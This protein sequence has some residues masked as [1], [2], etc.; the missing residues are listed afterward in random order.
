MRGFRIELGEVEDSLIR[1]P[2]VTT[3]AVLVK[4]KP[5]ML[6]AFVQLE[7]NAS[8][9][10]LELKMFAG[11]TLAKYMQPDRVIFLDALPM[12]TSG[13]TDRKAL[14]KLPTLPP[15]KKRPDP[16]PLSRRSARQSRFSMRPRVNPAL[17]LIQEIWE[18]LL[19]ASDVDE[20][21]NFFEV[22][23]NSVLAVEFLAKLKA[24]GITSITMRHFFMNPVASDLA[25]LIA[26]DRHFQSV[27][28]A[29]K[30]STLHR[31]RTT[32][33]DVYQATHENPALALVKQIW[34]IVLSTS[35]IDDDANFFEI[36]G[37]SIMAVDVITRF[38]SQNITTVSMR[39]FFQNPVASSLAL[40]IDDEAD[41][42][43]A[44]PSPSA[45][46]ARKS[47][48]S[49]RASGRVFSEL[50][51]TAEYEDDAEAGTL[52]TVTPFSR[53]LPMTVA[54]IVCSLC[55]VYAYFAPAAVVY[56]VMLYATEGL[57]LYAAMAMTPVACFLFFPM[58]LAF[59]A[60]LQLLILGRSVQPGVHSVNS[61]F[62]LRWWLAQRLQYVAEEFVLSG[63]LLETPM[64]FIYYRILG[65]KIGESVVLKSNALCDPSLIEIGDGAVL[66]HRSMLACST[67]VG[68]QL[69]LSR[70]VIGAQ[71]E[72][73]YNATVSL[74]TT[75]GTGAKLADY[76]VTLPNA[77]LEPHTEYV[78][79]PAEPVDCGKTM[80]REPQAYPLG[81]PEPMSMTFLTGVIKMI[82]FYATNL[83]LAAAS[84]FAYWV[85]VKCDYAPDL[86]LSY[87]AFAI[88]LMFPFQISPFLFF[89]TP[90][91]LDATYD[92]YVAH[93]DLGLAEVMCAWLLLFGTVFLAVFCAAIV[94]W[95]SVLRVVYDRPSCLEMK[96]VSISES[97][98]W[99]SRYAM[100]AAAPFLSG[101][102]YIPQFLNSWY[103][104]NGA[105]VG[106]GTW[107]GGEVITEPEQFKCG[108]GVMTGDRSF[109]AGQHDFL[110]SDGTRMLRRHMVE[111]Q[112]DAFLGEDAYV[113]P[114]AAV[115]KRGVI[116][117]PLSSALPT[118]EQEDYA[119]YFG[120]PPVLMNKRAPEEI[121]STLPSGCSRI[122]ESALLSTIVLTYTLSSFVTFLPC[123]IFLIWLSAS[124]Y[125]ENEHTVNEHTAVMFASMPLCHAMMV[126]T[127]VFI[128]NFFK[129]L[130]IGVMAPTKPE[131]LGILSY[132][133]MAKYLCNS[134]SYGI[135]PYV[136]IYQG[137]VSF[138]IR[139]G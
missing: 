20:D 96:R 65:A 108:S 54:Q 28:I 89:F 136:G 63:T 14:A 57:S 93:P 110:R 58:V 107:I 3:A 48:A 26:A 120:N 106:V 100:E 119:T 50:P 69:V 109:I 19:S 22:G 13:K 24:R 31:R 88:P 16:L 38:K 75:V 112:D 43:P 83:I 10:V 8:C 45:K 80:K 66:D 78:G 67:I 94:M 87:K 123:D 139:G 76:G 52:P 4:K 128:H 115:V 101:M 85:L 44:L 9:T 91:I 81:K 77:T 71:T 17:Q 47:M 84:A 98:Y 25:Q 30:R 105:S 73:G 51:P 138:T 55:L 90:G 12:N 74:G 79:T 104:V 127:T 111:I 117:G 21:S 68:D 103:W 130:T 61:L 5:D 116:V 15:A 72:I 2:Q 41:F 70:V 34:G 122:F 102:T 40:L 59:C 42:G 95:R 124:G 35:N 113:G 134:F 39:D 99:T 11:K 131:G 82:G 133:A 92:W 29:R 32:L 86:I 97:V 46:Q 60:L 1:H 132:Y 33:P 37:N 114:E 126:L 64:A 62:F 125:P 137:T 23:G 135:S 121:A 118:E 36:G 27:R 129:K 6:A 18:A 7:P 49:G 53:S 56:R